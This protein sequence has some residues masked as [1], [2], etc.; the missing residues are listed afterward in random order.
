MRQVTEGAARLVEARA[1]EEVRARLH[2]DLRACLRARVVAHL[3]R[4]EDSTSPFSDEVGVGESFTSPFSD[5]AGVGESPGDSGRR[6]GA[7]RR[8]RRRKKR[9]GMNKRN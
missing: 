8:R 4:E 5:E 7:P 3:D 6:A 9:K 1:H 2:H